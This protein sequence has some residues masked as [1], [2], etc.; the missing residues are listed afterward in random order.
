MYKNLLAF[1]ILLSFAPAAF[2][3]EMSVVSKRP[4]FRSDQDVKQVAAVLSHPAVS[5]TSLSKSGENCPL[6][7][8]EGDSEKPLQGRCRWQGTQTVVFD[9]A[10]PFKPSSKYR[11]EIRKGISSSDGKAVLSKNVSWTFET[12]RQELLE[13]APENN[14]RWVS[15]DSNFFLAFKYPV[16]PEEISSYLSLKEAGS[17]KEV[18][19]KVRFAEK[20]ELDSLW[21]YY[22]NI[23]TSSAVA[24]MP[25]SLEK[26]KHYVL[27]VK[28][29]LPAAG[30]S[31]GIENERKI[32][33]E[34][35]FPLKVLRA[36]KK[37]CLPY[38]PE[39]QFS[40]PV[41]Y[42][43][44]KNNIKISPNV[45]LNDDAS[46]SF[47][48]DH[49]GATWLG[50]EH[51]F[52]RL[53][54]AAFKPGTKYVITVS[55]EL[56]DIFGQK[57][58]KDSVHSFVTG[59]ICPSVQANGGFGVLESYYPLRH[60]VEA[61]NSGE[62][63]TQKLALRKDNF[64]P[65][66]LKGHENLPK[67]AFVS[68]WNPTEGLKNSKVYTFLDF[69]AVQEYANAGFFYAKMNVKNSEGDSY[70]ITIWDNAT[71][72]GITVKSSPDSVLLWVTFLKTGKPAAN[73]SLQLR[74]NDN[75][76]LWNG[77]TNK[78]GLAKAPGFSNL[79]IKSWKRWGRPEIW[80]FADSRNGTAVLNS[81]WNS[82]I[83]PW[84]FNVDYEYSPQKENYGASLFTDRGIY[85]TG[86]TVN[87]KGFIRK[88]ADGDWK[89][90]G[91]RNI[92]LSVY[93]SRENR[94]FS[95]S[96]SM[97]ES[98]S[99][100]SSFKVP[101]GSPAGTWRYSID[102]EDITGEEA[103]KRML[104]PWE[105]DSQ[106]LHFENYF[107]VEDYKPAAFDVNAVPLKKEFYLGDKFEAMAD[108]K[109][110]SGAS[111]AGA[112]AS[113]SVRLDQ[114]PFEPKGWKGYSFES[115]LFEPFSSETLASG[116][117]QL[118]SKG[119]LKT[120]VKLPKTFKG[121]RAL[122]AVYEAGI[123][124]PDGQN[125]FARGYAAVHRSGLYIGALQSRSYSKAGEPRSLSFVAVHP[126]GSPFP[127]REIKVETV[128]TQWYGSRRAGLG[129]R[130][131]WVNE[132]KET[133]IE[134]STFT[135]SNGPMSYSFTPKEGGSYFFR[136]SGK[137][138]K[139]RECELSSDFY[140]HGTGESW[141]SQQDND[142]LEMSVE[143]D[144]YK[145]GETAK[146][147]VKSPWE[148]VQALVTV[149]REGVMEEFIQKIENGASV[150]EIP[151]K[152][153]YIPNAY[154]SVVMVK[155]RSAKPECKGNECSDLGKPQGRFGYAYFT[156]KPENR[157]LKTII[158]T[159]KEE[160]RP[161]DTARITVKTE[162]EAGNPIA[163]EVA[164]S[165]ADEGVLALTSW[166]T[167]DI[168]SSFY[169]TRPLNVTTADNRLH[170]IGQRNYGEKGESRGGG[171][172]YS[173]AGVDLRSNFRASAYWNPSVKTSKNGE[174]SVSFTVPDNLTRFRLS[175]IAVAGR[176][177]GSG[178]TSFT[179]S[180]PLMLRP[181][182]PAF[183]RIG[184]D[185]AC[186]ALIQNFS[187]SSQSGALTSA[188]SGAVSINGA[189]LPKKFSVSSGS[190]KAIYSNCHA[191]KS[192][193]G[194]FAYAAQ[195]KNEK[196]GLRQEI[197]V[198]EQKEWETN[199]VF[200]TLDGSAEKNESVEIPYS[201]AEGQLSM[202]VSNSIASNLKGT[203]EYLLNYPY[204][205]LDARLAKAKVLA[206][207][208]KSKEAAEL[209]NTLASYQTSNGGFSY[210]NGGNFSDPYIT[211][212]YLE[213]A[214]PLRG[215]S[216]FKGNPVINKASEWLM[217]WARGDKK[218]IAYSYSE[219]ETSSA[220]AYA[221]YALSLYGKN[222]KDR[223]AQLYSLRNR[224]SIEGRSWLIRAM[225][226]AKYDKIA[227]K[228]L[229][230]ELLSQAKTTASSLFFED[231]DY[232]P[233]LH[234]SDAGATASA[235]SAMLEAYG[236]FN[237]DDKAA[238]WLLR[239]RKAKNYW[240]TIPENIASWQALKAYALRY[241][242][243]FSA[244]KTVL[245]V[246]GKT[247]F[248]SVLNAGKKKVSSSVDFKDVFAKNSK[249][250]VKLKSE[251]SGRVYY[252]Y[253]I[254]FLAQ[255]RE[256]PANEG[257]EI[258]R[259]IKPLDGKT[260]KA[261]GR[262]LITIT[263]KTPQD[264]L[265]VAVNEPVPAGLEIVN[266]SMPMAGGDGMSEA[267]ESSWRS[268]FTH[269]EQYEDRL[270]LMADYLSAGE[271]SYTYLAQAVTS[272]DF[273]VPAAKAECIYE[274][275]IF[276]TTAA[277]RMEIKP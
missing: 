153:N 131:E 97:T 251:G 124:A 267:M 23:S 165:A 234:S 176:R 65:F 33:F 34:T 61:V 174:A 141:W 36:P 51:A 107:K 200:G 10:E 17:A 132:K 192:G 271:H 38:N 108:G 158:K 257:F 139:G 54:G 171:G 31:L 129:G 187:P 211:A 213:A 269:S 188:I 197:Q 70:P 64:I 204:G 71:D 14:Q 32:E 217:S 218:D 9:P 166:K 47:A 231:N 226:K 76:I 110:M 1:A 59:D 95:K 30:S 252:G 127:G 167:P 247:H 6:Y 168:F 78:E 66:Y 228:R 89:N 105:S 186:G 68:A 19:L 13:S 273:F 220:K 276:G 8:F 203:E 206:S 118:N 90:S 180:K 149:E 163:A 196:D 11:A 259:S 261:G 83:E 142:I 182:L 112:K 264:R 134:T 99:F 236:G 85:R 253:R 48:P 137:D 3:A 72:L 88:L 56:K 109:Y 77:I 275:E 178:E 44:F 113:W 69:S 175:G 148:N 122:R 86:E 7:V 128:K 114:A 39:F 21:K 98:S 138:E 190:S 111:L 2:S 235:L 270:V 237:G 24:V 67:D 201:G 266:A 242:K 216:Y 181:M 80:V 106:R 125:L 170:I 260:L 92:R 194:V 100:S 144:S 232:M 87:I 123:T 82:G 156:V 147:F 193:T 162:D 40:N 191:D 214:F 205:L 169:G 103:D 183:A 245:S 57:L 5:L 84:R 210:W 157:A 102:E 37:E 256:E 43:D 164:I 198:K 94:I 101:D 63:K 62:I 233:W 74:D 230:D 160:Y 53:P 16:I 222:V 104:K 173:L 243:N 151:V 254:K 250:T 152:D 268:G 12:P 55:G 49:D 27:S 209:L 177:F 241:E 18:P 15:S 159:D 240:R 179:V 224:L 79:G 52:L 45:P 274:P 184:D 161:G 140:V 277:S 119:A 22:S 255:P 154:V 29:G 185:F 199:Y 263:V 212:M 221:I 227:M 202:E 120:S 272:G 42:A 73:V 248:S 225:N 25:G 117:K 249:E 136:I 41:R 75:K 207:T 26:G 116:T 133:V 143:K 91:F 96:V 189:E 115:D 229:S 135:S 20:K 239:E 4:L 58:G 262:A 130:L 195:G 60:P 215:N 121:R 258:S 244:K 93:D 219:N 208:G 28:S 50:S 223:I 145:V 238:M 46:G 246:A 155:G 172:G 146:I 35:I 150:I 81:T 265:F 126:D